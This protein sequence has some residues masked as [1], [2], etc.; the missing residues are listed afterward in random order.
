MAHYFLSLNVHEMCHNDV[1]DDLLLSNGNFA[2]AKLQ[3]TYD[4]TL[5]KFYKN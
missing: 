5:V 4:K 3:K 2:Y 1:T